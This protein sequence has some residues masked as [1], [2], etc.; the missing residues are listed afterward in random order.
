MKKLL[1]ALTLI[2]LAV[3]S[4]FWTSVH[5]QQPAER[6]FRRAPAKRIPNQYQV[7][8]KDVVTE[9]E[10]AVRQLAQ[11][12]SGR[13]LFMYRS[14]IKGFSVRMSE[15]RAQ[16]LAED[17]QVLFVEED[18][19][20]TLATT[21][22]GATWGLDRID[23]R[24]LPLDG[25][26]NYRPTGSGLGVT[27]YIID[28]GIRSTH[29]DFGGRVV[30]GFT[31]INDG[32]GTNDC[33][34]HGTHVAGTV[35][36]ATYGV[37]KQVTLV[38]VRVFPAIPFCSS[39]TTNAEIMAGIDWVTANHVAGTP[40]VAN[41]SIGGPASDALD[42]AV[43]NSIIDG[44]TYSIAA[45][46]WNA[47]ACTFSP[48][49]L[50]AAITVGA[51]DINDARWPISNYGPCVDVFAPGKDI[52]SLSNTDDTA[53]RLDSG[54]SMAAPHVAGAAAVYLQT[55]PTASPAEVA[56]AIVASA[57][58]NKVTNAGDGSPNLLLFASAKHMRDDLF[59]YRPGSG[60]AFLLKYDGNKDFIPVI[61]VGDN[62]SPPPNGIG[63]YDLL[64]LNDRVFPFDYNGDGKDDLFLYRPGT[65]SV[66]VLKFDC[67]QNFTSVIHVPDDGPTP[68]NGIGGFDLLSA[69]DRVFPFDYNGDG[70]DD[71][72]LY[73]PGSGSVFVLRSEGDGRFTAVV[74]VSDNGPTLP[75]GIGGYDLLSINDRVFPLDY[76]GDGKD[77]LFLYRPGSSAVSVLKFDSNGS[78]TKMGSF[79]RTIE[80]VFPF[81]YNGDGKAD[82]FLN[83]PSNNTQYVLKSE[84]NG[85]FT[86][87]NSFFQPIDR[88]FPFDYNGD[89]KDDLFFYWPGT[90]SVIVSKSLGNGN[91]TAFL[92]QKGIGG[93]D[94]LSINDRVFP[95][96]CDK[97]GNDDLFLYRP[98]TG[99]VFVLKYDGNGSFSLVFGVGDNGSVPPNG[100]GGFDLLSTRDQ[101]FALDFNH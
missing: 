82:L 9:V 68:E 53:D 48:A 88:V 49:R 14:A 69:N 45:D 25:N 21:Q 1:T 24:N 32:Q 66:F 90:G 98:G 86:Q 18:R 84:G 23:Q 7:V 85:N 2:L 33:V 79:S 64:S 17:P 62:G 60:S 37:A 26:Y 94:L 92:N 5:S 10:P 50:R 19:E 81:D 42:L 100:I 41:M 8:L 71:L 20:F 29:K 101:V 63:G 74:H 28:T 67:T 59:L 76:D 83:S 91:F 38:P 56:A 75:N 46:N 39:T 3:V 70:K 93:Y 58:R 31:A 52:T 54:T 61:G 22:S 97:D 27:A 95:F 72:F 6:K 78:F 36:S 89:G 47:D 99:A 44:I 34:G 30:T 87:V 40:A 43:A 55:N 13:P 15:E 65:G 4:L 12:Y 35:G 96:D 16:A 80:Q 51:T 57:T 77:E 11:R 73:R